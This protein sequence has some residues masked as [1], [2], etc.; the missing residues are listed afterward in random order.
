MFE[1]S[2]DE[3]VVVGLRLQVQ[4]SRTSS[5]VHAK[6]MNV[7]C[8][9]ACREND[10][11]SHA[12]VESVMHC[13][14]LWWVGPMTCTWCKWAMA[15]CFNSRVRFLSLSLALSF[16]FLFTFLSV[17]SVLSFPSCSLSHYLPKHL[18]GRHWA[19]QPFQWHVGL[20]VPRGNLW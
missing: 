17:L 19:R 8:W 3:F 2:C 15:M 13:S 12:H 7:W 11:L 5:H 10:D 16:L 20:G 14:L 18:A 1:E 9:L 4:F 6:S